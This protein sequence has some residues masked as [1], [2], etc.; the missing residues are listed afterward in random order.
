METPNDYWKEMNMELDN[1]MKNSK[2]ENFYM[3]LKVKHISKLNVK[4]SKKIKPKI[5]VY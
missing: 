4:F 1:R 3:E 5:C 2:N